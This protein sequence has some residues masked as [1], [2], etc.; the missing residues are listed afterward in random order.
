MSTPSS[1]PSDT[2]RRKKKNP[3]QIPEWHHQQELILK[4]GSEIGS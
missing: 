4:R 3:D 1:K 2:P